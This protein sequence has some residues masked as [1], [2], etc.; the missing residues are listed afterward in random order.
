MKWSTVAAALL[1]GIAPMAFAPVAAAHDGEKHDLTIRGCVKAGVNKGT[2]VMTQVSE[3]PAPGEFAMP[4]SAHGRRV[5][6]WLK[7]VKDLSL[8]AG[9]MVQVTGRLDSIKKSE[10][11]VKTGKQKNGDLYVEFEGPGKDVKAR[12]SDVGTEVGTAGRLAS[13][14]NDIPTFLA[15]VNVRSIVVQAETCQ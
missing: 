4:P 5:V 10:I 12:N 14:K 6:Y 8:H 13:E 7:D 9:H 11:E 15:I 2:F 3:L 1:I